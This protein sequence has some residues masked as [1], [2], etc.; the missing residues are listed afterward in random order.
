LV[1]TVAAVV[2]SGLTAST[3]T[4]PSV[5]AER[6]EGLATTDVSTTPVI[7]AVGADDEVALPHEAKKAP[8]VKAIIISANFFIKRPPNL[9]FHLV[10]RAHLAAHFF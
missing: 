3:V 7:W 5:V 10:N 1:V 4:P 2:P 6:A 9:C 8:I